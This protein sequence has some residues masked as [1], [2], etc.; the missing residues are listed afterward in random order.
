[1]TRFLLVRHGQTPW[2]AQ[3]RLQG[4]TDIALSKAGRVQ[5]EKL[6]HRLKT[7]TIHSL[8]SS[9]LS[10]A[11][12]TALAIAQHHPHLTVETL[13]TLA[14]FGMGPLEG[15]VIEDIHAEHGEDF[16][17]DDV[18]RA[19]LGIELMGPTVVYFRGW[20]SE[21][22]QTHPDKTV[23]VSS[24]GGKLLRFLDAFSFSPEDRKHVSKT[25]LGNCS[26]TIVEADE[27]QHRLALFSCERHL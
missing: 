9:P 11:H 4:L 14:E 8:F 13:P 22:T 3:R 7:E 21:L 17:T 12:D 24:H 1:M 6:G 26:L 23:L 20:I 5:A 2:N 25:H 19:R 10:R 18:E 27:N 16:W 15:K